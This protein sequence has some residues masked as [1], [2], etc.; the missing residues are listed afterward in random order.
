MWHPHSGHR[1]STSS[2]WLIIRSLYLVDIRGRVTVPLSP[3]FSWFQ[4]GNRHFSDS[5]EQQLRTRGEE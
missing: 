3:S 5:G 4:G 2:F 1:G